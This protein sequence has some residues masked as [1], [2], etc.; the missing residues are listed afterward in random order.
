MATQWEECCVGVMVALPGRACI[1]WHL[2]WR[3]REVL[4][5]VGLGAI[6]SANFSLIYSLIEMLLLGLG[7]A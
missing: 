4:V 5:L 3:F 7:M 1:F 2:G 6:C